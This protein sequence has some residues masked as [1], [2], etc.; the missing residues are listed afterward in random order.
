LVNER[1]VRVAVVNVQRLRIA[2]G[3]VH[4]LHA[5]RDRIAPA[6]N[7]QRRH[8]AQLEILRRDVQSLEVISNQ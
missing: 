8:A 3:V 1:P 2:R 7:P 5:R 4:C 6:G